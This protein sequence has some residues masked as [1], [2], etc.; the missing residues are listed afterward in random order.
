MRIQILSLKGI[1]PNV[2]PYIQ[3][4]WGCCAEGIARWSMMLHQ[5]KWIHAFALRMINVSYYTASFCKETRETKRGL[6]GREYRVLNASLV[7]EELMS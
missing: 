3:H 6:K 1:N 2:P 4:V 5:G 7:R